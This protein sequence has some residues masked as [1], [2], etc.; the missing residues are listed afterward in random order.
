MEFVPFQI[1]NVTSALLWSAVLI[2]L[3]AMGTAAMGPLAHV[4]HAIFG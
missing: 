1:S 3:G 2:A 4:T